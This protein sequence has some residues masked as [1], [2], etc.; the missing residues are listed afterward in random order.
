MNSEATLRN[1]L[2]ETADQFLSFLIA[3]EEY[4]IEILKVQEIKSWGPYTPLPKSPDYV[5][6]VINLR[7]AIV[8]I[9]DLRRRFGL[10][11]TDY[12]ATTAVIIVRTEDSEQARIIG[13]VVD[14]VSEVHHLTPDAIQDA[15]E[16]PNAEK[17]SYVRGF[18]QIGEKLIILV[19]LDPIIAASLQQIQQISENS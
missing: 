11:P 17:A 3:E 8:P 4:G 19:N 1:E 10:P 12:T 9:I 5:L 14:S 13:L 18:G 2:S 16:H 7:G 6:G 15:S